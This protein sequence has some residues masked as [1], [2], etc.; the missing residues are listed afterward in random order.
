MEKKRRRTVQYGSSRVHHR[1]GVAR[2][3]GVVL[4]WVCDVVLNEIHALCA[5]VAASALEIPFWRVE[6]AVTQGTP[7]HP[8]SSAQRICIE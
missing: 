7:L 1:V 5:S 8:R 6:I 4:F 2:F 3:S